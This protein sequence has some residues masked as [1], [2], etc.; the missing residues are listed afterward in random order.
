MASS[1]SPQ[2]SYEELV[3][4]NARLRQEVEALRQVQNDCV[5]G[6]G[7]A[8]PVE[9]AAV[10]D[11]LPPVERLTAAHIARYSRQLLVADF[12]VDAQRKLLSSSVLVVGAG[13]WGCRGLTSEYPPCMTGSVRH[14]V[15][16]CL[17]NAHEP[18]HPDTTEHA[19]RGAGG[20]G[21]SALLY[22]AAA[23][24]GRLGVVDMD[25]VDASNLHRQVIHTEARQGLNKVRVRLCDFRC[26]AVGSVV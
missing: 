10:P 13:G 19:V 5:G 15:R 20:L 8:G 22:L 18:R 17:H 11:P 23:G 7:H 9:P 6:G 12:G 14:G 1:A 24:V 21:S 3:A 2:P 26:I 16:R 4:E 25:T